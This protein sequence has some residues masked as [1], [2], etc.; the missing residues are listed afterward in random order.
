MTQSC[1]ICQHRRTEQVLSSD[2]ID[3]D[4]EHYCLAKEQT[5]DSHK[6]AKWCKKYKW[7]GDPI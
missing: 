1:C 5:I 2:R 4:L 3:V 7:N 6:D